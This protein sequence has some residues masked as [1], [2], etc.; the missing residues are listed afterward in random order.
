MSGYPM[1]S[2]SIVAWFKEVRDAIRKHDASKVTDFAILLNLRDGYDS[3]MS[4]L[5]A[6]FPIKGKWAGV[7]HDEIPQRVRDWKSE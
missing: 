3:M 5:D 6:N 2:T 7:H 4:F 1:Q